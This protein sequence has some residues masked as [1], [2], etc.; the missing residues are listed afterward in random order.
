[1][2]GHS[3]LDSF[4]IS[5]HKYALTRIYIRIQYAVEDSGRY[6]LRHGIQWCKYFSFKRHFK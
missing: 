2:S 6:G 4:A 3:V 5:S 1:M